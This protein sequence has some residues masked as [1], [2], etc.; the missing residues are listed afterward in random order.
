MTLTVYSSGGDQAEGRRIPSDSHSSSW[1][2]EQEAGPREHAGQPL[3][4][5][6]LLSQQCAVHVREGPGR[7]SE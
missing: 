3:Q 1:L 4:A 5:L 6:L 2:L 7:S